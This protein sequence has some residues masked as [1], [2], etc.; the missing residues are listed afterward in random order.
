[1]ATTTA[2]GPLFSTDLISPDVL[3]AL[4]EG[5]SCRPLERKDYGNGFLDVLRV[6]TT[7]GD[8]TEEQWNERYDWMASRN[9]EYY[10]LCITDSSNAIV[11]TGALIVERKFIHQLGLVGH[12]ED[13]A[14][15]KDQQGKKL[16]LRIIQALDFVAEKNQEQTAPSSPKEQGAQPPPPTE[17]PTSTSPPE[18]P[19][20]EK[21]TPYNLTDA[22][23]PKLPYSG[24]SPSLWTLV[25]CAPANFTPPH[26]LSVCRNLLENPNLTASHLARAELSYAS[27]TDATFN[28]EA[29]TAEA[30]AGMI[31]H[32]RAE[33]RP[34]MM[35]E[36]GGGEEEGGGG[37]LK[38]YKLEYTVVRKLV[39]RN[40]KLDDSLMQ[41][42]HLFVSEENVGFTDV[43]GQLAN[44]PQDHQ[45]ENEGGVKVERYLVIYIPHVSHPDEIPFYHPKVRALAILYTYFPSGPSGSPNSPSSSSSSSSTTTTTSIPATGLLSIHYTLFPTHPLDNR[46]SRTALKLAEIIHKHARGRQ[47]GYKKRVHHDQ[48][49]P[50]KRFQ[51]TYA[52]L[53]GKYAKDLIEGWVEQ[54]PPEKHVFEDLGIA[55]FLEELWVDMYGGGNGEEKAGES[56]EGKGDAEQK[57]KRAQG[58]FPGFVDIGCG[59]GLLVSILNAQGWSGWGFDARRRKTWDT[60]FLP[61]HPALTTATTTTRAENLKAMLL[62]PCIIQ[63]TPSS[64]SSTSDNDSASTAAPPPSS[65]S[66]STSLTSQTPHHN[67]IFPA[68]TFII[69]NHADELTPWT[70]LLAHLNASPFIAIPCCS[71]DFGGTRFRAPAHTKHVVSDPATEASKKKNKQPSAYASLCSWVCHLTEMIG[72]RVEKEHLRIP[73]TRNVAVVGRTMVGDDQKHGDI[74]K[75]LEFLRDLVENEMGGLSVEQV[76]AMWMKSGDGLLKPGKGGH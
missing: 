70:P 36:L 29:E 50:Q 7:V 6:L 73:S 13:I 43:N 42:C 35:A 46:L 34:R 54:T 18:T 14:V 48:I 9:D 62:D 22:A 55:A 38:G 3:K 66:T 2:E 10:L 23:T 16:G 65:T 64:F 44:Q 5:Y 56:E 17:A 74:E 76:W 60:L 68:H 63:P 27:F 41:T 33:C 12:I 69:S 30:L 49:I 37:M 71:H 4:P 75:R 47:A 53:K 61:P 8:I 11:G 45:E 31:K 57:R 51:D 59:N 26:F 20:G 25:Q 24:L 72:Y 58:N 52:H 32:L 67:G 21:F 19:I 39:P 28:S 40:P 1:M 15:A